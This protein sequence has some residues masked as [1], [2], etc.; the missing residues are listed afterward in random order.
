MEAGW[1]SGSRVVE[2]SNGS[3]VVE[4]SKGSRVV[5][6]SKGSRVVEWS[7][8]YTNHLKEK[9]NVQITK[10]SQHPPMKHTPPPQFKEAHPPPQFEDEC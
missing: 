5:E 10:Q 6:W 8:Q 3:R 2:C 4:W 1:L 7:K 9:R